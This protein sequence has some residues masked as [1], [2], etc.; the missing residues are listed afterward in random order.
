MKVN[1]RKILKNEKKRDTDPHKVLLLLFL[2]KIVLLCSVKKIVEY[3][4]QSVLLKS[5]R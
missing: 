2:E 1:Q 4:S 5:W 3:Y